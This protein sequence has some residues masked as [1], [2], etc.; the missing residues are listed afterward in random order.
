MVSAESVVNVVWSVG[1]IAAILAIAAVGGAFP[2]GVDLL[3]SRVRIDVLFPF[4]NSLSAGIF[5]GGG[6]LHLLPE[7]SMMCSAA[8][9]DHFP[10]GAACCTV[11]FIFMVAV[12][13]ILVPHHS[14][15]AI[16]RKESATVVYPTVSESSVQPDVENDSGDV[17]PERK[18]SA[19]VLSP[20]VS[21]S[22]V[23]SVVEDDTDVVQPDLKTRLAPL[24]TPAVLF[25]ALIFHSFVAGLGM[26]V[27]DFYSDWVAGAA[28][29]AA[30]LSHK[31][32]AAMALAS[33]FLNKGLN[34]LWTL[35]VIAAFSLVTPAGIVTGI[36][37]KTAT[38]GPN[39]TA[40][41]GLGLTASAGTFLYVGI[42]E[43]LVDGLKHHGT[44]WGKV[45]MVGLALAGVGVMG[46]LCLVHSE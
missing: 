39:R 27:I 20:S 36:V 10:V 6:L 2:V 34:A 44:V 29:L 11:V 40:I 14:H 28:M 32:F 33:A 43:L 13:A 8:I 4:L 1:V 21:E 38:A 37:L 18:G 15:A 16:E 25:F 35:G 7:G 45:A 30:I 46:A 9:N 17:Q 31:G 24:A 41:T 3:K 12:E 5:L 42:V 23:L 26:G 19:S 22:S